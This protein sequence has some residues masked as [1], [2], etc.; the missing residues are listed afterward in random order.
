MIRAWYCDP[1][2]SERDNNWSV[3]R[4]LD[5]SPDEWTTD[6]PRRRRAGLPDFFPEL[7]GEAN[8]EAHR[9]LHDYL[10]IVIRIAKERE[11]LKNESGS[12]DRDSVWE[13]VKNAG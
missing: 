6:A 1:V 3:A 12:V 4:H 8:D 2:R 10:R 11:E 13:D 9:W 7:V 5:S